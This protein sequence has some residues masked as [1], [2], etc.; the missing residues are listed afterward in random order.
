MEQLTAGVI[1]LVLGYAAAVQLCQLLR[2][3][4]SSSQ[5]HCLRL[6]HFSMIAAVVELQYRF[7]RLQQ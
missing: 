5:A 2:D 3:D 4:A 1:W 6:Q 7:Y